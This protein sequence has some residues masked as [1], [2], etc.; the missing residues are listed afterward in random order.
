MVCAALGVQHKRKQP[1]HI[2]LKRK[3]CK[4]GFCYSKAT[5][6]VIN[7]VLSISQNEHIVCSI[8]FI[9]I[10]KVYQKIWDKQMEGKDYRANFRKELM[11]YAIVIKLGRCRCKWNRK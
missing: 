4:S 8:L 10:W 6:D 2:H 9:C 1:Q 5:F 11:K 7:K 3:C